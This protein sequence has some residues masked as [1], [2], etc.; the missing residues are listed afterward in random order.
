MFLQDEILVLLVNID[1]TVNNIDDT[2]NNIDDTVNNI[3]ETV[4]SQTERVSQTISFHD[5]F[6]LDKEGAV[7]VLLDTSD[8]GT[9]AV[10]HVAANLPCNG[11]SDPLDRDAGTDTPDVSIVA[12]EATGDLTPVIDSDSTAQDTGFVG[13]D[14]T[15]VFHGTLTSDEALHPITDVIIINNGP[16]DVALDN[17]VITITGTYE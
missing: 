1:D 10:V 14:K 4:S 6:K 2:V 13:P 12:G 11:D 9:L 17:S 8:S 3:E 16:D 15:C 5:N 7:L